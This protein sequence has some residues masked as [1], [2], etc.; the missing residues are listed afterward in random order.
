[1][2]RFKEVLLSVWREAC[3]HIEISESAAGIAELLAAH[4]P[5]ESLLVER[6]VPEHNLIA[7]VAV[8]PR[9]LAA[10]MTGSRECSPAEMKKLLAWVKRG[11]IAAPKDGR[12]RMKPDPIISLLALPDGE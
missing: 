3:Q 6:I 11:E 5:L 8:A 4:V 10:G 1:M 9:P 12:D 7:T 2:D